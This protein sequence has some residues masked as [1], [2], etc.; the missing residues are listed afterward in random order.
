MNTREY[1][2]T[3]EP[4]SA[5]QNW[6]AAKM[7]A[8]PSDEHRAALWQEAHYSQNRIGGRFSDRLHDAFVSYQLGGIARLT[9]PLAQALAGEAS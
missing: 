7:L 4:F 8:L 9:S 6:F 3:Y 5:S 2:E 1:W